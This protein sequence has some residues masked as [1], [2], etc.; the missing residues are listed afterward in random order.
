[1]GAGRMVE[2]GATIHNHKRIRQ[3]LFSVYGNVISSVRPKGLAQIPVPSLSQG[4]V[5]PK[6]G[7]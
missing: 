1:M 5:A 2:A 6:A 4:H 7:P 3:K